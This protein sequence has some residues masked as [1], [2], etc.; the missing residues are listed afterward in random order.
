[1]A[2]PFIG[3]IRMF[4]GNFNPHGYAFCDGQLLLV[5]QNQ[6]LFSLLGTLYGGD[7]ETT[8][9]LPDLR[10]RLA[11]DAGR[12]A[13]LTARSV[14]QSSGSETATISAGQLANHNHQMR[15]GETPDADF[16][17]NH[18]LADTP[19]VNSFNLSEPDVE[20]GVRTGPAGVENPQSHANVMPFTCIH[21]I[22]ALIGLYPSIN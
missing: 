16:P 12:G 22:I 1:M 11:I 7:G 3:E 6:A 9:R 17:G 20:M 5:S 2:D 18:L 8:F 10:G 13:G 21:Y 14:G 15:T 4:A 19:G